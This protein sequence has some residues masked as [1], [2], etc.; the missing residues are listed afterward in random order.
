[1]FGTR[2]DEIVAGVDIVVDT[3]A[4]LLE[5][6]GGEHIAEQEVSKQELRAVVGQ[7][8]ERVVAG[9]AEVGEERR[10]VWIASVQ[11]LYKIC[12]VTSNAYILNC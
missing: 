9:E 12:L 8:G 1:L 5:A 3:I 4:G 2:R 10:P 7:G 6:S 11:S